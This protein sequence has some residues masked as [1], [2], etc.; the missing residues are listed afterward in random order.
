[1]SSVSASEILAS[2]GRVLD[3]RSKYVRKENTSKSVSSDFDTFFSHVWGSHPKARWLGI[4]WHVNWMR[5]AIAAVVITAITAGVTSFFIDGRKWTKFEQSVGL[6]ARSILAVIG[7]VLVVLLL[8]TFE[9]LYPQHK[10]CF[11]DRCCIGQDSVD[12]KLEGVKEI[13]SILA[14]SRSLVIL[15]SEDYFQRLWCIYEI[16]IY[17]SH[18]LANPAE[19]RKIVFVPLRIVFLALLLTLVDLVSTVLLQSNV[20]SL[21]SKQQ[22]KDFVWVSVVFSVTTAALIYCFSFLWHEGLIR[23]HKQLANFTLSDVQCSEESDRAVLVA[24]IEQRFN[25]KQ[26][27]EAYVRKEVLGQIAVRP[28]IRF[29]FWI[30]LPS[31]LALFGY[32]NVITQRMG[33]FCFAQIHSSTKVAKR[34]DSFC[35]ILD[36][37]TIEN[38][39]IMLVE[40][41]AALL[42]Y[43]VLVSL[44]LLYIKPVSAAS[45]NVRHVLH[46]IGLAFL[47][48][49]TYANSLQFTNQLL[50]GCLKLGA[51]SLIALAIFAVYKFTRIGVSS[52]SDVANKSGKAD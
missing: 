33:L 35:A 34:D 16:A 19:K 41:I 49:A 32:I 13:P 18:M 8:F 11:L 4:L 23:Y 12:A 39:L 17:R 21:I 10:Q 1:M 30:C 9:R 27:F 22:A 40:L 44:T 50:A 14:K 2:F 36:R 24:D 20:R 6:T 29:L 42:Y 45:A 25:G 3:S 26:N 37:T 48:G 43:P 31:V 52:L 5:S 38:V 7:T 46:L 28:K 47:T 15:L 51:L